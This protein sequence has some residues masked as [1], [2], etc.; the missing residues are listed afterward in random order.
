MLWTRVLSE[1]NLLAVLVAGVV[2]IVLGL[3]WFQPK[4]FGN[5]WVKLS[6]KELKPATRW[7][8]AGMIAHLFMTLVLAVIVKLCAVTNALQGAVVGILACL[9]FVATILPASLSGRRCLSGRT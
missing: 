9:G 8:P 3:V 5:A 6:G 2:H 1:V 4:L 7:I